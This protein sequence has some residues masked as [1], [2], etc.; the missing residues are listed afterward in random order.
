[1]FTFKGRIFKREEGL[2][3]KREG[4]CCMKDSVC[5]YT[6]SSTL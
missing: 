1:M 4:V 3:L 2:N 5:T 6:Q